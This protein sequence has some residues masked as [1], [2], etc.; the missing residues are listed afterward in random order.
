MTPR[1][2]RLAP[3]DRPPA[4]REGSREQSASDHRQGEVA[5]GDGE[6]GDERAGLPSVSSRSRAVLPL[7]VPGAGENR[8]EASVA[9]CRA[10]VPEGSIPTFR[11]GR[12]GLAPP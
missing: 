5:P 9:L 1:C 11:G 10:G 7:D 3:R 12:G 4:A 6:R 8:A 2:P